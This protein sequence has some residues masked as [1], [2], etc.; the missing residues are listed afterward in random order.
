MAVNP[1]LRSF[2]GSINGRAYTCHQLTLSIFSFLKTNRG[3]IMTTG[4]GQRFSQALEEMKRQRRAD[5]KYTLIRS[6]LIGDVLAFFK[7]NGEIIHSAAVVDIE[8]LPQV[9][10]NNSR[11]EVIIAPFDAAL[12]NRNTFIP[13]LFAAK[14]IEGRCKF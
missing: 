6:P 5:A 13:Y 8:P 10:Q 14:E 11:A 2:I 12:R 1:A 7:I 9:V 4:E 3:Q